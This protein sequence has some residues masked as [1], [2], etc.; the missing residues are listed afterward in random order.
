MEEVGKAKWS[1]WNSGVSKAGNA[2]VRDLMADVRSTDAMLS[3]LIDTLV[4][5]VKNGIPQRT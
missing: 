4:G 3:F 1:V 5:E 2:S